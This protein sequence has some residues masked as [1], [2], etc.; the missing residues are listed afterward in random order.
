MHLFF[1]AIGGAGIGPLALVAHQA[2]F[3]VSGSDKQ[4][5]EF[6]NYL[7]SQGIKDIYIGQNLENIR[8]AHRKNPIDWYVYSSAVLIEN[9]D[10]P[11]IKFCEDNGIKISKRDELLNFIINDRKFKL[12]AVAGTHGKS[13]TTAMIIWLFKELGLPI[14]Y[15]LGAKMNE[16]KHG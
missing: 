3:E 4:P 10:S 16:Q 14:S 6:L 15:S 8:R 11:E 2:G 1:S 12:I 7:K 9:P 5:S 13:T